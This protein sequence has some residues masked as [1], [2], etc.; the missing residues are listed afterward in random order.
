MYLL[1]LFLYMYFMNKDIA[2]IDYFA[3][4]DNL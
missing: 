3:P 2:L 4:N 1:F